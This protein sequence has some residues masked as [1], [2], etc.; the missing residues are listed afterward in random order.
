MIRE[1]QEEKILI[2][3]VG[4]PYSGKTTWARTMIHPIVSPDSIRLSVTGKR[5]HSPIEPLVWVIANVMVRSLFAAGHSFVILDATNISKKRREA[6][7]SSEWNT[8]FKIFDTSKEE[9]VRRAVENSDT[10]IIPIIDRMA[11]EHEPLE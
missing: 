11:K 9:C 7:V 3:T 5:F 4:L 6:W 8:Q 1:S 2:C 10:D